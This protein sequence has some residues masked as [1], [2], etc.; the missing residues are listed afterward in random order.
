MNDF[1]ES[2]EA[3]NSRFSFRA[4]HTVPGFGSQKDDPLLDK[5]SSVYSAMGGQAD[6][7]NLAAERPNIF[8]DSESPEPSFD[9]Q[10]DLMGRDKQ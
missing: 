9:Q 5:E 10:N 3:L 2:V 4:D 6:I 1:I 8:G 7:F